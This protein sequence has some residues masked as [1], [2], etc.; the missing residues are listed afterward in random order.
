MKKSTNKVILNVDVSD[1]TISLHT[2]FRLTPDI[3]L[4]L[5]R[6]AVGV[7]F[8]NT[9][10]YTINVCYGKCFDQNTVLQSVYKV[11]LAHTKGD[12]FDVVSENGDIIA[13][14]GN[15][16]SSTNIDVDAT[17][18]ELHKVAQDSGIV[19]KE[20]IEK[21]DAVE[22][23]R[24]IFREAMDKKDKQLRKEWRAGNRATSE[25][26]LKMVTDCLGKVVSDEEKPLILVYRKI[27]ELRHALDD[28]MIECPL[29]G[30][31][32]KVFRYLDSHLVAA[33]SSVALM[34]KDICGV[35]SDITD[36]VND[37]PTPSKGLVTDM[38]ISDD[39]EEERVTYESSGEHPM[40]IELL[41]DGG[42]V[43][44]EEFKSLI[45]GAIKCRD[46]GIIKIGDVRAYSDDRS[47]V[48]YLY[49]AEKPSVVEGVER[50][51]TKQETDTLCD[52]HA[53][54]EGDKVWF[55]TSDSSCRGIGYFKCVSE[56]GHIYVSV[57]G[58]QLPIIAKTV[59]KI[60]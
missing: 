5:E 18:A 46:G 34:L 21:E 55:T 52:N 39:G 4:Q 58:R 8:C 16:S 25:A 38:Y 27:L 19:P 2:N 50:K 36:G 7:V 32:M 42:T 47:N 1:R 54:K 45:N 22:E 24:D 51:T 9:T 59:K 60:N 41:H 23:V 3:K 35:E 6:N 13:T 29:N 49:L 20:V 10:L 12:N 30:K 33:N 17:L 44:A 40:S 48:L 56:R 11:I 37:M 15:S 31:Q 57:D 43:S 28:A 53:L 14:Y 26:V